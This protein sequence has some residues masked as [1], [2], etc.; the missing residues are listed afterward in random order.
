MQD[1]AFGQSVRALEEIGF[2]S[3][4]F[5]LVQHYHRD[6]QRALTEE[7]A[8]KTPLHNVFEL[9]VDPIVDNIPDKIHDVLGVT[10][11][12]EKLLGSVFE[13][14]QFIEKVAFGTKIRLPTA[15][16]L[17]ATKF[18]SLPKRTKD[19]KKWKDIADI[20]ALIWYSG[21]ST[22]QLKARVLDLLSQKSIR[23]AFSGV[24]DGDL[25]RAAGAIDTDLDEMKNVVN[26]F[27]NRT[28]PENA[29]R[30]KDSTASRES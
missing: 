16:V 23:V 25:Q 4:G 3:V 21:K 11:V 12:D 24:E 19:H 1:S 10:P 28:V 26:N 2:Y 7:Q 30:G 20:Y 27:I 5:R 9:Y 14:G 13:R 8:R 22:T 6:T 17:L 15:S 18:M 29:D